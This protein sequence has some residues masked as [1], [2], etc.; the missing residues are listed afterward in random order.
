L[1]WFFEIGR[2]SPLKVT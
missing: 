1:I 2:T